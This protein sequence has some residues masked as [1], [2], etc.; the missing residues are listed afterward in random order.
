MAAQVRRVSIRAY[1]RSRGGTFF[2]SVARCA[3]RGLS[4]LARGNRGKH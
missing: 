4:P 2:G 3:N 1:P